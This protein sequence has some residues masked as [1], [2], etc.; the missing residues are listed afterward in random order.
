MSRRV[1][2]NLGYEGNA[3]DVAIEIPDEEPTPWDRDSRLSVVGKPAPRV[4]GSLKATGAAHYS[5]DIA[6][7]GMLYGAILRS[8]YPRARVRDIDFS[9]AQRLNGV[10]AVLA[11]DDRRSIAGAGQGRRQRSTRLTGA[12]D[13]GVEIGGRVS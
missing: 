9:G 8:P 1:T 2:L 11:L 13:D 10:R 12:D 7:P 4:D 5:Y 6:L 3:R